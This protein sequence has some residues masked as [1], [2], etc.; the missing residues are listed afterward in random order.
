MNDFIDIGK[1]FDYIHTRTNHFF[2]TSISC[3][4]NNPKQASIYT[5]GGITL[6]CLLLTLPLL[7]RLDHILP[8]LS[9]DGLSC[10]SLSSAPSESS[11]ASWE[12]EMAEPTAVPVARPVTAGLDATVSTRASSPL[13]TLEGAEEGGVG[14][15]SNSG[16]LGGWLRRVLRCGGRRGDGQEEG[17]GRILYPSDLCTLPFALLVLSNLVRCLFYISHIRI[18]GRMDWI[19]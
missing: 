5:S 10:S 19:G 12:R 4:S 6:F 18:Y 7:G 13:S 14:S 15:R 16:G 11:L 8:F 9:R 17:S 3:F 1:D 2:L